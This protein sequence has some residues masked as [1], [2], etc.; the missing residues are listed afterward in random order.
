MGKYCIGIDVGPTRTSV[1]LFNE[2]VQL[3]SENRL[4]TDQEWTAEETADQLAA[5][6]QNL[7]QE[8]GLGS[9]ALSGI[10]AAFPSYV[11]FNHGMLLETSFM[12]ALSDTP[13]RD[14]LQARLHSPVYLDNDGNAAALAEYKLGAGIGHDDMV[15]AVLATGIGGGLILNGKLYRGMHGMAGEIGHIFVS[16]SIGYPCSCGVTGCVQSIC[17]GAHM[18][19]FVTD[20]IKEGEDSDILN[21]AGTFSAIDM[22]AVSRALRAG[23]TLALEVVNRSAE[24]L[25]RMFHRHRGRRRYSR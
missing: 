14:L 5:A 10:G 3:L 19:K 20:R 1:G 21:Y 15:Y 13:M 24:Y 11:D 23:D 4:M 2:N 9:N 18:A 8:N 7:L 12:P 25:G 17:S 22:V 6:A 16:D